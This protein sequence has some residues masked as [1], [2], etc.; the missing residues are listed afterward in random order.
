MVDETAHLA[1]ADR[2]IAA[3]ELRIT[4]QEQRV[5][6]AEAAGEDTTE[7]KRLLEN[8]RET[9]EQL[10]IHRRMIIEEM[11]DNPSPDHKNAG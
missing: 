5:A 10:Y 1:Q 3:A 2:H 9:L 8:F 7:S 4:E 11:H 6:A